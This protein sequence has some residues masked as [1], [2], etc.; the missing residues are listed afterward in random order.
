M[1]LFLRIIKTSWQGFWRN[2]WLSLVAIF[3]MVQVLLLVGI[4]LSLNVG[5]GRAIQTINN[6]I[7]VA[8]FFKEYVPEADIT[9]YQTKIS[10]VD[11]IKS[12]QFISQEEALAK[13][14]AS[15]Q[16]NQ[17][18]IEVID[19]DASFFPTSLEIK[20][21]NPDL[22][23]QVI[24]QIKKQDTDGII[25][26]TSWEKNQIVIEKLRKIN[27][28]LVLGNV[29]ISLILLIVA[30]LIIFNTI[31][32]TIFTRKEEIEIMKLVGATDWYIRWP[33]V[34]EG[35]LYGFIGALLAFGL[36]I[37]MYQ[38]LIW[39]LGS[40]Y[41]SWQSVSKTIGDFG[42]LFALR[43]FVFQLIFG[44]FVGSFS[45]YL[46]TKRYLRI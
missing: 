19:G 13:Y 30:L 35:V 29:G 46:A 40:S 43:L 5:V 6:Q 27:K 33:F 21:N 44:I 18:L 9:S 38:G 8:V 37:L 39:F 11:N 7:D 4:F 12:I 25:A 45:S 14:V 26:T 1:Q 16:Y 41:W 24:E 22:L 31:R 28:L 36:T 42:Y 23:E 17:E 10:S 3:I 34:L 20:V 15:S 32:I 2:G